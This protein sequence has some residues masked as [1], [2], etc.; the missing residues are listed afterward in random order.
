MGAWE[1]MKIGRL[2]SLEKQATVQRLS[3]TVSS[4]S[5]GLGDPSKL[6]SQ[7]EEPFVPKISKGDVDFLLRDINS[8]DLGDEGMRVQLPQLSRE[9]WL[10]RAMNSRFEQ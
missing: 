5:Q 3:R 2:P 6:S 7:H 10:R 1:D 4:E 9:A 8:N